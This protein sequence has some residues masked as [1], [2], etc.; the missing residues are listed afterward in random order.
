MLLLVDQKR[1]SLSFTLL[2]ACYSQLDVVHDAYLL[3]Q[4]QNTPQKK[5]AEIQNDL[6]FGTVFQTGMT[7]VRTSSLRFVTGML[8]LLLESGNIVS[9]ARTKVRFQSLADRGYNSNVFL[10]AGLSLLTMLLSRTGALK[11]VQPDTSDAPTPEELVQ[12]CVGDN[13]NVRLSLIFR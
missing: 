12:W 8:G 6:F 5:E 7:L 10:Q 3:D 13:L 11:Q 2:V 9:L 4:L 1:I